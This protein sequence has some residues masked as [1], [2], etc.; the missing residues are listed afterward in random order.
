M[1]VEEIANVPG[2]PTGRADVIFGGVVWLITIMKALNVDKVIVSDR[3][4]LEGYA[5]KKGLKV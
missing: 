1:S 2:V 4:N 3:D 5:L